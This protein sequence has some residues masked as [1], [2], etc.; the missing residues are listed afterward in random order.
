MRKITLVAL[1]LVGIFLISSSTYKAS[2][3]MITLY[4]YQSE[5]G[6]AVFSRIVPNNNYESLEDIH[7][8]AWTQQDILNVN[9]VAL[10]FNTS[11]IAQDVVVKRAYLNLYFNP[12]S[13]YDKILGGK[14]SVGNVGFKIEVIDTEWN[15]KTVTWSTQPDVDPTLKAIFKKKKDSKANY[16]KLDITKLIQNMINKPV[17]QRYGLMLKLIN[18][19][20]YNVYF[21]SSGNHPDV[22]LR[23]SLQIKY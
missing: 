20:P 3:D 4:S 11:E 16:L 21:F 5:R 15:E 18:E 12:T 14:G 19:E 9:R 22:K 7:L 6:D 17:D 23:P 13:K 2:S 1:L 10:D 8:Y